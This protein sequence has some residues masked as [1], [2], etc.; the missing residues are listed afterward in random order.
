MKGIDELYE[1]ATQ[2]FESNGY[3]VTQG[4]NS[5]T[6]YGHS[7]Y[8][9]VNQNDIAKEN[10]GLGFQVRVS[11]HSTGD[12]RILNRE[13]F[14][15]NESDIEVVYNRINYWFHPEEYKNVVAVKNKVVQIEVGENDL[16]PSDSIISER[17]AKSGSKRY[18]IKRT[19]QNDGVVPTHIK[20]GFKLPFKPNSNFLFEDGGNLDD[21][22]LG[23]IISDFGL[24][25]IIDDLEK[26]A[27]QPKKKKIVSKKAAKEEKIFGDFIFADDDPYRINSGLRNV[28]YEFIKAQNQREPN[29]PEETKLLLLLKQWV[30]SVQESDNIAASKPLL[31]KLKEQYPLFFAPEYPIGTIMFRGLQ[32]VN[33]NMVEE[34][35]KMELSDFV[36]YK[37][38]PNDNSYFQN[39]KNRYVLFKKPISYTPSKPVQ[40][41]T[42]NIEKAKYFYGEG[43]LITKQDNDFFINENTLEKIYGSDESENIH[44]GK[45]FDNNVY[46]ALNFAFFSKQILPSLIE[47]ESSKE[48]FIEATEKLKF[49]YGGNTNSRM[50][51]IKRGGITYGKSHAAGGI[52]VKNESTGDMLEVEGGEGIVNKRS[53][54]SDKKVKLN[55]K[56]MTICEAVSQLNQLE[57]GVQFSC[58][59]VSDRQFIEA[60]AKG[61]ELERGTRT[62]QEHIQVLRD[63]YA[64]RITPKQASKRIAKDHI[65]E[66]SQYYS[67]LAKMEGKMADGGFV[68]LYDDYDK[69]AG[70]IIE[71]GNKY[72]TGK[73][74]SNIKAYAES[75]KTQKEAKQKIKSTQMEDG[76]KMFDRETDDLLSDIHIKYAKGG[77]VDT[78]NI[79]DY[80]DE[81]AS[82]KNKFLKA[83]DEYQLLVTQGLDVKENKKLPKQEKDQLLEELR[84]KAMEAKSNAEEERKE[85]V[86]MREVKSPFYAPQLAD[87]GTIISKA[88]KKAIDK[89]VS[90]KYK[91]KFKDP[92]FP[93]KGIDVFLYINS[94]SMRGTLSFSIGTRNLFAKYDA[95]WGVIIDN[96]LGKHL[97]IALPSYRLLVERKSKSLQVD[98]SFYFAMSFVGYEETAM[99]ILKGLTSYSYYE[100]TILDKDKSPSPYI[101]VDA[102]TNPNVPTNPTS[103]TKTEKEMEDEIMRW[104][105]KKVEERKDVNTMKYQFSHLLRYILYNQNG[106]TRKD[107][108]ELIELAKQAIVFGNESAKLEKNGIPID[109]FVMKLVIQKYI[110]LSDQI[111]EKIMLFVQYKSDVENELTRIAAHIPYIAELDTFDKD[112]II[113]IK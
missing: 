54:A 7:R 67:K 86:E 107:F 28:A 44:I 111:E 109:S 88:N 21:F 56:E 74:W 89:G 61:G 25:D 105:A 31:I 110:D 78:T 50:K 63:L 58:D 39:A 91:L 3:E 26:K 37:D 42:Q 12:R 112:Y 13:Q 5:K 47:K 18:T 55:G 35:S 83:N 81:F 68:T 90:G 45:R 43:M 101:V 19:Y 46:L 36:L 2:K 85:F 69:S 49:A 17:V 87:G 98:I 30:D 72:W 103:T 64:K 102:T 14:I 104:I 62:E 41:W 99:A 53:M 59:D 92:S 23:S 9:Y 27:S 34:L 73:N 70:Y 10:S 65:K 11:D 106:G 79:G 48:P 38:N 66:D 75:Y 96:I 71:K 29:T 77:S 8:F 24:E 15:F 33:T 4:S 93:Q 6:D 1:I 94:Q 52:P 60:M 32:R 51:K 100:K 22:D 113:K 20:S 95:M 80:A 84:K 40:S 97:K 76:G 16:Q 108:N 82:R 57:G